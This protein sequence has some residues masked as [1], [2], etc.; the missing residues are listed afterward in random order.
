MSEESEAPNPAEPPTEPVEPPADAPPD[1]AEPPDP[2]DSWNS[3]DSA[4]LGESPA[5]ALSR[6]REHARNAASEAV[7]SLRALLDAAALGISAQP[8]EHHRIFASLA[9][10]LDGLA[11]RFSSGNIATPDVSSVILEALNAEI[12]RWE[13]RSQDDA[14][15][16]A[17][18]RAFLG[19][20]EILWEFG[21]RAPGPAKS[22]T[23]D[24]TARDPA[25]P[26]DPKTP[27]R[28]PPRVQR[29]EVQG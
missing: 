23:E 22:A 16:R 11:E 9:G 2:R 14:D 29:V 1:P 13:A 26:R 8:A 18:L 28:K 12:A 6:A 27:R 21:I 25:T 7:R 5:E 17:V 10:T 15:S 4:D 24:D 3:A 19:M 20:R